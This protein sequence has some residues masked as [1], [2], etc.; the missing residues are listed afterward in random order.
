MCNKTDEP[1]TTFPTDLAVSGNASLSADVGSHSLHLYATRVNN[2]EDNRI[3]K[4]IS[5]HLTLE[6]VEK[7]INGLKHKLIL[8]YEARV[9]RL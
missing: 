2:R 7:L 4:E 9:Q 6:E 3:E 5:M 8:C 1:V